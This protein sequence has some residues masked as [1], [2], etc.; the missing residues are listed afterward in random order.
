[1][2]ENMRK[3]QTA[4]GALPES[5]MSLQEKETQQ[6]DVEKSISCKQKFDGKKERWK[7]ISDMASVLPAVAGC[8][9]CAG[10]L[11]RGFFVVSDSFHKKSVRVFGGV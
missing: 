9:L 5:I 1:M 11:Q 10:C 8:Y 6:N 7:S 4:D 3:K 2:Q